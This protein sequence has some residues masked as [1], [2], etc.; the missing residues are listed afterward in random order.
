[1][2]NKLINKVLIEGEVSK[3]AYSSKGDSVYFITIKQET[4][5]AKYKWAHYFSVY[6]V[7]PLAATLS[8][9]VEKN[10]HARLLIE[11]ELRTHVSK[12]KELKTSIYATKIVDLTEKEKN[13]D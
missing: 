10:P 11:G 5:S 6:A 7:K 2:N 1:M 12:T 8:S 4:V 9:I 13:D 3:G